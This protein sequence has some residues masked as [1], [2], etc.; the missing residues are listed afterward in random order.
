MLEGTSYLGLTVRELCLNPRESDSPAFLLANRLPWFA[1]TVKP[2]HERTVHEGLTAKGM[3][4]FLPTSWSTRRWSDREKRLQVPLFPGYVFCRLEPAGRVP[5]LRTPGVRSI[6]SFGSEMIP[7]PEPE[8]EQIRRM[9]A[10][11]SAAEPWPFLKAG[12]RVF[13]HDGP[14]A[15]MEGILVEARNTC[16]VVVG[17]ELLQRSVAVQLDR[18]HVTPLGPR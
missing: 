9:L 15:G 6:V 5:V 8:I 16:R 1:L 7:V 3:E 11:G 13:V 12:Q 4:S 10:S 14:M 17:I 18:H 2:Q